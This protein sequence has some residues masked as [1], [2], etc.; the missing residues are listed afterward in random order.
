MVRF[1][2]LAAVV[3]VLW[4]LMGC[5]SLAVAP[6]SAAQPV[7]EEGP[8]TLDTPGYCALS[9]LRVATYWAYDAGFAF[10]VFEY[11]DADRASAF[12]VWNICVAVHSDEEIRGLILDPNKR[13]E[14]AGG[15]YQ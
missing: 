1:G 5:V 3:V 11:S 12:E 13:D 7:E 15:M 6:A 9:G 2:M 10:N 4:W 14:T 8:L